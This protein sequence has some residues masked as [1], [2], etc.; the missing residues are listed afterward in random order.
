MMRSCSRKSHHLRGKSARTIA[1]KRTNSATAARQRG[2]VAAVTSAV[3]E[4]RAHGMEQRPIASCTFRYI[5]RRQARGTGPTFRWAE[6]AQR[7]SQR[8]AAKS[9]T[10]NCTCPIAHTPSHALAAPT[11]I[12]WSATACEG[13][14]YLL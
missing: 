8:V 1:D 6:Q 12:P 2:R 13:T 3:R 9:C 4:G 11:H 7:L 14:S 5:L 10:C